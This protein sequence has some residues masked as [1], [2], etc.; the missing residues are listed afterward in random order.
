MCHHEQ[1][2]RSFCRFTHLLSFLRVHGHWFFDHHRYT[3]LECRNRLRC[4]QI[5]RCAHHH[6]LCNSIVEQGFHSFILTRNSKL[7]CKCCHRINFVIDDRRQLKPQILRRSRVDLVDVTSA[8]KCNF[9]AFS[10]KRIV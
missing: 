1:S 9:H 10:F 5:I 3:C 6:R 7:L 4:V 2:A 8:C